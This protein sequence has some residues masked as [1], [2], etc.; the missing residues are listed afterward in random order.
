MERPVVVGYCLNAKKMRRS[1]S[2]PAE[3]SSTPVWRGGGLADLLAGGSLDPA[4][5]LSFEPFEGC[6]DQRFD[7][8]IHKLTEDLMEEERTGRAS[9]KLAAVRAYV[10][11][12]P[13][14][15]LVDPLE[16]VRGLVSRLRMHEG[17]R[18]IARGRG[19]VADRAFLLARTHEDLRLALQRGALKLPLMCKPVDACGSAESHRMAVVLSLEGVAE[20]PLPCV[21]SEYQDHG[22]TLFKAYVIDA[23]VMVF[24]RKS[25]PDIG[26]LAQPVDSLLFDSR[27]AYPT[28]A[29]FARGQTD[30]GHTPAREDSRLGVSR[31]ADEFR[32]VAAAIRE[33]FGLGVFGFDAIAPGDAGPLVVVDVNFFPSYKEV[34]DFPRRFMRMLAR[35]ARESPSLQPGEFD[36]EQ[37]ARLDPIGGAQLRREAQ[38]R[39]DADSVLD[40]L[41]PSRAREWRLSVRAVEYRSADLRW[42]ALVSDELCVLG[43]LSVPLEYSLEAQVLHGGGAASVLVAQEGCEVRQLQRWTVLRRTGGGCAVVVETRVE[44]AGAMALLAG[45]LLAQAGAAQDALFARLALSS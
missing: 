5:A 39:A 11:K 32:A 30:G 42:S 3:C 25:L 26:D 37:F 34:A 23:E 28:R 12:H 1:D 7:V 6:C 4:L 24:A 18:R 33:E 19:V 16:S 38:L 44:V 41:H 15:V 20:A 40:M 2:D 9:D 14:T 10:L 27:L 36:R 13:R 21:A 29:A 35:K 45:A 43:L 17:L 22:E 31:S 8:I